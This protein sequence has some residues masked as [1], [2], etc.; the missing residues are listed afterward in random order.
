MIGMDTKAFVNCVGQILNQ[1]TEANKYRQVYSFCLFF[2]FFAK[3]ILLN[4]NR[5]YN[6]LLAY[7]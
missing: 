2:S 7:S 3:K 6:N 4:A 1:A 5:T